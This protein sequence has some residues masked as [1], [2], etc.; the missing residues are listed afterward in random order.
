M[1]PGCYTITLGRLSLAVVSLVRIVQRRRTVGK[2]IVTG[3]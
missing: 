2:S 1:Y 3:C